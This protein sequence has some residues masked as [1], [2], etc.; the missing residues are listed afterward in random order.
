MI[1]TAVATATYQP[2]GEFLRVGPSSRP[3][4]PSSLS[5]LLLCALLLPGLAPPLRLLPPPRP[6]RPLATLPQVPGTP[7]PCSLRVWQPP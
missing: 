3:L 1:A 2:P 6:T 7:N 5:V 4:P